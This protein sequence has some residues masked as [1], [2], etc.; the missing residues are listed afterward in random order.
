MRHLSGM[1]LVALAGYALYL[2]L[3]YGQQRGMMFPGTGMP[4]NGVGSGLP[5]AGPEGAQR[6]DLAASFGTVQAVY[7]PA[8]GARS[9]AP[10]AIYFHG[11]A[12]FV[13][14]NLHLL[15]AL[16]AQGVHVLLPEFPGYAGTDGRPS[17]D[18]LAEAGRLAYDWLMAREDVDAARIIGIGRSVG[19]GP[20]TE[21]GAERP[22]AALVLMAPF[23]SVADF[24]RRLGAPAFLVRDRFDNR[25]RVAAFEGPVLVMHGRLDGIIPHAHGEAVAEAARRGELVTLGCGHNDC[26]FFG[27]EGIARIT[28]FL[29]R[30]GLLDAPADEPL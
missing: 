8:K 14:Q 16:A 1:L 27:T 12:E 9:P 18:S 2:G 23:T 21:L 19:S 28:D 26:P 25:A 5:G 24:A 7:L 17:R 29:R 4:W 20:A 15:Q 11:N 6:V 13:D 10:A 22:L 30:A 3:L